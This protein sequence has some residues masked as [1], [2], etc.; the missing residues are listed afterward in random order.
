MDA[1]NSIKIG[2]VGAA[3]FFAVWKLLA[4][5]TIPFSFDWKLVL[6]VII[7]ASLSDLIINLL[8]KKGWLIY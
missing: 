3:V 7:A 5:Y 8:R 6:I 4:P 1:K 2:L